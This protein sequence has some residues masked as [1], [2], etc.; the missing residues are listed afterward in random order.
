MSEFSDLQKRAM[1]IR[2][3]YNELNKQ[4]GHKAW[5]GSAYVMGLAGDIGDLLKLVMAK[6]NFS[7]VKG[8]GDVIDKLRHELGDCLW[9][10]L[11]IA[12]YYSIDLKEAFLGT[13]D[14]LEV[15]M[16]GGQE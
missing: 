13:M 15:R 3:R 5:D 8:G 4:H 6:E 16:A 11:V 14:E 7:D 1:D 10:L 2:T 12:E 9:S